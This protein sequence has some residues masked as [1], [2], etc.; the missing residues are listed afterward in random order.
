MTEY[1][2]FRTG[3]AT[4]PLTASATN[5]LLRD[6]DPA[7][8]YAL[9]YFRSVL[10]THLEPRLLT[11]ATRVNLAISGAVAYTTNID[12]GKHPLDTR[13]RFPL[14][15]VYRQRRKYGRRTV[16]WAERTGTWG[17]SYLLPVMSTLQ[18]ETLDPILKAVGDVL[19][20]RIEQGFDPAFAAGQRVWAAAGIEEIALDADESGVFTVPEGQQYFNGWT[21]TLI[22]KERTMPV[23]AGP[24]TGIDTNEDLVTPGD[25]TEPSFVAMKSDITKPGPAT[26]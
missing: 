8:F 17:V 20:D 22:V 19:D 5:S 24:L 4:Y 9:A 23:T 12:P 14:L 2:S 18:A 1:S 11:E 6:A 16:N 3:G 10:I 15:A 26:G 25:E 21:G 13:F 7:L